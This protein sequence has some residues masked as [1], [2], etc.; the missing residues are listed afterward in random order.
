MRKFNK[1]LIA[2][3]TTRN[4]KE[5]PFLLVACW[6]ITHFGLVIV[7]YI[8]AKMK[9]VFTRNTEKADACWGIS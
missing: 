4:M 3:E 9:V 1:L 8:F 5:N 2:Y 7:E 6:C